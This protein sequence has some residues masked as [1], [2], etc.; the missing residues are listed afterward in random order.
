VNA[1]ETP[2]SINWPR[3]YRFGLALEGMAAWHLLLTLSFILLIGVLAIF[4]ALSALA[5][6]GHPETAIFV[7]GYSLGVSGVGLIWSSVLALFSFIV[8]NRAFRKRDWPIVRG[9]GALGAA[10][11]LVAFIVWPISALVGAVIAYKMID[12][13]LRKRLEST[14]L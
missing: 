10:V 1:G 8:L 14:P 4:V 6:G 13:K 3:R 12:G 2:G 9:P 7:V 5:A 11:A